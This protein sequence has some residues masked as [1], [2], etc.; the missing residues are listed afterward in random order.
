MAFFPSF[1]LKWIVI[2]ALALL[3]V[4]YINVD[5]RTM[6]VRGLM[7]TGLFKADIKNDR[8]RLVES[9]SWKAPGEVTFVNADGRKIKLS[10]KKGK[11]V[12]INFWAT[13]CPP[14]RAEMPSISSLQRKLENNKGFE[15]MMVEVDKKPEA[16]INFMTKGQYNLP[17]Y[18]PVSFIPPEIFD[19]NLPTTMVISADGTIVYH[20][21]GAANYDH[22][23]FLKFI[24]GLSK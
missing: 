18:S 21:I 10:E 23:D 14:C 8:I 1:K 2:T 17:V 15:I 13:W 4:I 3:A 16:A 11:V 7:R 12:F 5:A 20:H 19:G 6:V 9:K 24:S 22:P